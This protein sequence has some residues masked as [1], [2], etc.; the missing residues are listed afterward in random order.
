MQYRPDAIP[1]E[2]IAALARA[3]DWAG[4]GSAAEWVQRCKEDAAQLWRVGDVWA[5][6]EVCQ[7]RNGLGIH[8]VA[9]AG[10]FTHEIMREIEAW[11]K[12]IG[13][14]AA[15]FSGRRGWLRRLPDYELTAITCVKEL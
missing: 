11:A 6:S 4:V 1:D 15:Y 7:Q 2:A 12:S 13:C 10:A 8:I 5:I 14:K 3:F 9:M